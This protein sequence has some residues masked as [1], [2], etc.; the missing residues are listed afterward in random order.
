MS[1]KKGIY[2]FTLLGLLLGVTL[3]SLYRYHNETAFY[4]MSITL[5]CLLYALAYNE[6]H[7]L[8]L[9]ASSFI[10]AL[11]LAFPILPLGAGF[12]LD[13]T[14]HM[15]TFLCAFPVFIYV[16]HSFHYA[17][18]HDNTWKIHYSSLFAAVWNT[19]SL[20]FIAS[21]FSSLANLLIILAAFIF[22]AV[23]YNYL[24][25]L[26]FENHHFY[27]IINVTLFFIGL[28]IGQ[29]N[30]N[31]IHSLRFLLLRMMY[32]LFPFLA[33]ISIVYFILYLVSTTPKGEEY[34]NPLFILI[35]LVSIGILF[36]NAY[37]QDG[38]ATQE[39][40]TPYWLI[41]LLKIYR[42]VLLLLT[43]MM[44]YRIVHE[45]YLDVNIIVYLCAIL[46]FSL[47]YALS[48]WGT[49]ADERKWIY[50]GNIG[51]ALFFLIALYLLNLPYL[52]IT[53][54]VGTIPVAAQQ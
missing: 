17:L 16:G 39:T 28:G 25:T 51:T 45:N 30:I 27:M 32:Y 11:V 49:E 5:F 18:H 42:V 1:A 44:T 53:F 2:I 33:L 36:F 52:P 6:K 50:A 54:H 47:V 31:I 15:L 3:D 4:Y 23:G 46:L 37:F 9:L 35:I 21:I 20:L 38:K 41:L 19:I 26:Y 12:D 29:Q 10:V 43:V 24:W 14:E 48:I 13:N 8:R 22:K 34:V 40:Q 7:S